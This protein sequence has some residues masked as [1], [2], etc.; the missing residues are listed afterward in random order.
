[1]TL[2]T[3]FT[4]LSHPLH[5]VQNRLLLVSLTVKRISSTD[6]PATASYK[7]KLLIAL[8]NSIFIVLLDI[9]EKNISVIDEEWVGRLLDF[10]T[11]GVV[12]R[13]F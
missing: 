12:E 7:K 2:Y 4:R 1:M 3:Y 5:F 8:H 6:T 13:N 10:R 9:W 11:S